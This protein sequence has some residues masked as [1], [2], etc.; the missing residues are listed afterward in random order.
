MPRFRARPGKTRPIVQTGS[1]GEN[2][3]Q[4]QLT[5]DTAT[6]NVT[7]YKAGNVKRTTDA[8]CRPRGR[9]PAGRCGRCHRQEGAG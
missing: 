6:K 9:L 4:I 2:V 3:G 7:A 1:Y 8:G 5:V